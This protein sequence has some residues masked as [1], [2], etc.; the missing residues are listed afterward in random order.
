MSAEILRET[1]RMEHQLKV[2]LCPFKLVYSPKVLINVSLPAASFLFKRFPAS[3]FLFKSRP[4][5]VF[6]VL[7]DYILI[8]FDRG[9][10]INVAVFT[11]IFRDGNQPFFELKIN[12][13]N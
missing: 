12:Q 13:L 10:Y 5:S 8:R 6:Y 11:K 4:A 3:I 9:V 1:W 2:R 7:L